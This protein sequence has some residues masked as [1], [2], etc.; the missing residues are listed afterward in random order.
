MKKLYIILFLAVI[1]NSANSQTAGPNVPTTNITTGSGSS[2]GNLG[3]VAAVDNNPAYVDL[4]QPPLC[5]SFQ[6]YYSNFAN[7]T[8]FGFS[9]PVNA[10]VTGIQLDIMQRVSSPGGGIHDSLLMLAVT[11]MTYG[12]DYANDSNW[13]DTPTVRTY[14]GPND[15]WGYAW[16]PADIN[17]PTFGLY[18][19][20][21]NSDYDQPASV[22]HLTMTVYYQVGSGISKQ[23]FQNISTEFSRNSLIVEGI[24][25][26]LKS[27]ELEVSNLA[28]QLIYSEKY[29]NLNGN[30]IETDATLWDS[31]IYF[32][33]L[34]SESGV[35]TRKLVLER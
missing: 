17:D 28:G 3:G 19:S 35:Q 32:V 12:S 31:G 26:D 14:G 25:A 6:C 15:T 16:T 22:D 34:R 4:F 30:S 18:Y 24:P 27:V 1:F 23:S 29:F 13:F 10:V 21:T 11:G 9:I 20:V 33:R 8:G 7:W 2:W 5:T